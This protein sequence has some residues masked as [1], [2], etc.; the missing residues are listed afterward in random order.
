MYLGVSY[1][2]MLIALGT[3]KIVSQGVQVQ[4]IFEA[5]KKLGFTFRLRRRIDL[6]SDTGILGCRSKDWK[7]E[8]LVLLREG[9]VID[10]QDWQL[11]DADDYLKVHAATAISL[12][13]V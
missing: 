12:M 10:A 9:I 13:V 4:Q 3:D 2:Q 7:T 6:D 8:H 1:E 11:W 5:A